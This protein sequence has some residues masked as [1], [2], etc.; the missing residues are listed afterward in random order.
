MKTCLGLLVSAACLTVAVAQSGKV[1]EEE[2][3]VHSKIFNDYTRTP[4]VL[5]GYQ[6]ET[7]AFANGG[8]LL[9][10]LRDRS[11]DDAT[12]D[13]VI[14][15]VS[16]A[17]TRQNYIAASD[18]EDTDLLIYVT[19][20]A[21]DGITMLRA[22]V[23]GGG[24]DFLANGIDGRWYG[25]SSLMNDFNA[26][27]DGTNLGN[28]A[29]LGYREAMLDHKNL[30]AWG[31]NGSVYDDLAADVEEPRYFVILTAFDFRMAWKE[32]KLVPLWSTR[33][34]IATLGN[35][36]TAALPDISMF[37]SRFFGRDSGGLVR[38]L[39]P[40]GK[41]DMADVQILGAVEEPAK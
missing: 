28:A 38:R 2:I 34:N 3:A 1:E 16:P 25:D 27:R 13:Q 26:V 21:T 12:F 18:P 7:F 24:R 11:I 6:A 23:F 22:P 5:G 19:W 33:Y 14:R 9:G 4:S 30:R 36:F 40:I 39:N 10:N 15:L 17:L 32:K 37:A 41:V 20:G 31:V 8:A 29:L 35:N